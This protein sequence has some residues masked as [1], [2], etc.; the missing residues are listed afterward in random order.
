MLRTG[1]L[2]VSGLFAA[3]LAM[4]Q[5]SSLK[6]PRVKVKPATEAEAVAVTNGA[7]VA[8]AWCDSLGYVWNLA[9]AGISG[10]TINVTGS[11]DI[12]GASPAAGTLTLA[13]GLPLDVTATVN[14]GCYCNA[15][16]QMVLT[17]SGGYFTGTAYAFG[18]CEGSAPVTLGKC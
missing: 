7:E 13:K 10:R 1:L 8:S 15:Y 9:G 3:S 14:P 11:A 16:H 4:G 12:C 18:G 5:S 2:V 17:F 6:Q